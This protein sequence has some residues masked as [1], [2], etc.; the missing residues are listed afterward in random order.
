MPLISSGEALSRETVAEKRNEFR[1]QSKKMSEERK[2]LIH[3]PFVAE[4]QRSVN[5]SSLGPKSSR[6]G[7][8]ESPVRNKTISGR[9]MMVGGKEFADG[10]TVHANSRIELELPSGWST[11]SSKYGMPRGEPGSV[12]FVILGDGLELFHS[13]LI[14][15]HFLH[16]VS[17]DIR[18]LK[19]L[20]LETRD[21]GDGNACDHSTWIEPK[22]FRDPQPIIDKSYSGP[23]PPKSLVP[24]E[25]KTWQHFDSL[26]ARVELT[27]DGTHISRII[28]NFP[29][30]PLVKADFQTIANA[31]QLQLLDLSHSGIAFSLESRSGSLPTTSPAFQFFMRQ[32]LPPLDRALKKAYPRLLP[33]LMIC[34]VIAY[35]DRNNVAIAK[36][37]MS[38]DFPAFD[39]AVIGFGAG[40]F[41]FGYFLLEIPGSLIFER[42]S[43]NKW[44]CR[45]MVTWGILAAATAFVTTPMQFYIV[46]FFLGLAE[47]GF[48][49][50]VIV[51]LTHWFSKK[52]RAR[53]LALFLV[54]SPIAMIIGQIVSRTMINIGTIQIIDGIEIEHPR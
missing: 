53:A 2:G 45:I 28:L 52:D 26:S 30:A 17:V 36:L 35:V 33:V 13:K 11:F 41:F 38:K 16:E 39:N 4:N 6:V 48:F 18:G 44:I 54:A 51:Y 42:W 24:E 40:I 8:G 23:E 25:V 43:A 37:T 32:P 27:S 46:R 47:A 49:P 9:P 3:L 34:N 22:L 21:G 29:T 14:R 1:E 50:G 19:T 12:A 5:V 15:T 31:R 20:V 7:W 10:L